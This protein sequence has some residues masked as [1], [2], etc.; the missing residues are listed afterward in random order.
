VCASYLGAVQTALP[1]RPSS[2]YLAQGALVFAGSTYLNVAGFVFH[3]V[4]Q[5]SLGPAGYGTFYALL[6]AMTIVTSL[7]TIAIPV[8][9]RFA[10]EFRALDDGAHLRG[11]VVGATRALAIGAA[12]VVLASLVA[13]VPLG[14]Y[15]RAP[16]WA[17]PA[18]AFLLVAVVVSTTY[19]AISQG[20]LEFKGYAVSMF[21]D[22]TTKTIATIAFAAIGWKLFGAIGGFFAGSAVGSAIS[23]VQVLRPALRSPEEPVRYDWRRIAYAAAGSAA[24]AI[25]AAVIGNVDVIVVRGA[26]DSTQA[27]L[28]AA[29][30]Q[31]AKILLFGVAFVPQILLPQ[32]TDRRARGES[33]RG[34]LL[35]SLVIFGACGGACL[36]VFAFFGP[37]VV[38]VLG[39]ARYEPAAALL[40]WYGVA[41]LF[42]ALV[43]LLGTYGI[44]THRFAFGWPAVVGSVA[45]V[46]FI[47]LYH[48]ALEIVVRSLATGTGLT[49]LGVALALGLQSRAQSRGAVA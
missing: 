16:A 8:L 34:V 25:C 5:R 32:A 1:G 22:G 43:A 36:L 14:A 38:R 48:P 17:I 46:G 49:A 21:L 30:A 33:T 29:A 15:F 24:L 23:L 6:A 45:T 47:A 4:V 18:T 26:F 19:R 35:S 44:A 11:L 13:S 3:A 7:T 31:A 41:M 39:G 37:L 10:A 28:Y 2:S 27:G 42:T 12:L 9:T 40:V 20:L